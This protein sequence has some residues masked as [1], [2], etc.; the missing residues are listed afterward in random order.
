MDVAQAKAELELCCHALPLNSRWHTQTCESQ[1]PALLCRAWAALQ[2]AGRTLRRR[3][4]S[5]RRAEQR[6]FLWFTRFNMSASVEREGRAGQGSTVLRLLLPAPRSVPD[7]VL[8]VTALLRLRN[9]CMY[10]SVYTVFNIPEY[11]EASSRTSNVVGGF[12]S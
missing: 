12:I 11:F 8:Q 2:K 5:P 9:V 6:R 7:T 1:K 10:L 3:Q 4:R